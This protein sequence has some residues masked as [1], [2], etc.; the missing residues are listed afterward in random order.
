MRKLLEKRC[1]LMLVFVAAF[2]PVV[3]MAWAAPTAVKLGPWYT[4]GPLKAPAF[5][6]VLFPEKGVDLSAK[7]PAGQ[8][9]WTPRPQWH[10]GQPQE[11][12]GGDHVSTYLFRTITDGQGRAGH[13][14][15]RQRRR[16]GGVAQRQEAALE[17]RCPRRLAQR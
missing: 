12:P 6:D 2:L 8:P 4:T 15:P 1:V 17:E 16:V 5:S 3:R 11:L 10:D 14:R 9:L 13:R 7:G